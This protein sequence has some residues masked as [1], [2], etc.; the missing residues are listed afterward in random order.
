M[1][2]LKEIA[3]NSFSSLLSDYKAQIYFIINSGSKTSTVFLFKENEGHPFGKLRL[4][5]GTNLVEKEYN[6]IK[7]IRTSVNNGDF[8]DTIP[9]IYNIQKFGRQHVASH[10]YIIGKSLIPEKRDIVPCSEGFLF[11]EF[12]MTL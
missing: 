3:K 6:V 7:A 2:Y 9:I 1:N 4:S 10:S 8:L 11:I 12:F 5:T